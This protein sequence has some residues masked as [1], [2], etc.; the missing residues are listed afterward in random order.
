MTVRILRGDCRELLK[1]L[2]NES[3]HTVVTS[4]P[5]WGLRDYGVEPSIWGGK[6]DCQHEFGEVGKRHRGGPPGDGDALRGRDQTARAE[7]GDVFTGQTCAHCGAWRGC[8]GLE[9]TPQMYV[10]HLVEVFAEVHRVLR[11]DGT[12][13][14]NLGDSYATGAGKVGDAPGGGEQGARWR[15]ETT[16]HRD[17]K[18]RPH[19]QP[20]ENGRGEPQVER[21][22]SLRDGSHAGKHTAMAAMGPMTQPNRMP[23]PGLKPKDLV[24]VPAR[25][26]LALQAWGWWVRQDIIWAKPNPMPESV[27]DRCT[28]SHEYIFLLAKSERYYYD[29]VSIAEPAVQSGRQ[30]ADKI[31]GDKGDDVHHSPGGVFIGSET[32]NKRSVWEI[33]TQPFPDAHFATFPPALIEPCILAG[34]SERGCCP[35]C[36]NPWERVIEAEAPDG[37]KA[38][39][40]GGKAYDET[41]APLMGNNMIDSGVRGSF[42]ADRGVLK[43]STAGWQP[44]C[45]C[46]E[47]ETRPAVVMDPFG[48]AGTT[49]LVADRLGRDAVL[50]ELNPTYAA[51][52]E[53]RI[54]GDSP[55]FAAVVVE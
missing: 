25:A 48:G 54:V 22:R 52:G 6:A 31:G 51:M 41:G 37:R 27:T 34:T 42:N 33:T 4:P 43:R 1:T 44:T 15:G 45:A 47:H 35:T 9:P 8:L 38:I 49:G 24:M 10:D 20:I 19:G 30:R 7:T 12:V 21:T 5:Y 17:E 3:V 13:W 40:K 14:L 36:G 11:A 26:A 16:R 32:R 29:A 46:G 53:R 28:K 2:P 50:C 18:R 39:M 23:I 55:L